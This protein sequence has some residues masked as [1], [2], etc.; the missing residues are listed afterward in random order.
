M[1]VWWFFNKMRFRTQTI[2][3]SRDIFAW[4]RNTG[5]R[6]LFTRRLDG[7]PSGSLG[8]E[9]LAYRLIY[10]VISNGNFS[11]LDS[12]WVHAYGISSNG[13]AV[14]FIDSTN[15]F[16][17]PWRLQYWSRASGFSQVV[18]TN[19]F[20]ND[21]HPQFIGFNQLAFQSARR[22]INGTN[23][24]WEVFVFNPELGK[25]SRQAASDPQLSR[26]YLLD[27]RISEDEEDLALHTSDPLLPNDLNN[28]FDIYLFG[29][30][31][32]RIDLV[33]GFSPPLHLS[34]AMGNSSLFP[35][36]ISKNGRFAIFSSYA[37]NLTPLG[38]QPRKQQL[39]LYDLSLSNLT[40]LSTNLNGRPCNGNI[41]AAA[42][43]RSGRFVAF[44]SL[45]GDL[46][47]GDTNYLNDVFLIDRTDGIVRKLQDGMLFSSP[48]LTFFG[49]EE[50]LYLVYPTTLTR[51]DLTTGSKSTLTS[52]NFSANLASFPATYTLSVLAPSLPSTISVSQTNFSCIIAPQRGDSSS[53]PLPPTIH[54]IFVLR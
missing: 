24:S 20:Q 40:L 6:N 39:Y 13:N 5:K 41:S 34:T 38:N 27:F 49:S 51:F 18:A 26:A 22:P 42:I 33:S 3:L 50:F 17:G 14:W 45:A 48:K 4:D 46:V 52:I 12:D 54:S 31:R 44:T 32:S 16:G 47:V 28:A 37:N 25:L 2:F 9:V 8:N 36:S 10:Q 29:K 35:E 53:I 43:S 11:A 30:N 23:G 21:F 1:G 19:D 15:A 7:S